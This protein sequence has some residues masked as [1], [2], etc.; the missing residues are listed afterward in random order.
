MLD[1]KLLREQTALVKKNLEKRNDPEKLKMLS[2]FL[3]Y[4]R[5]WRDNLK[6]IEEIR[7]RRNVLTKEM[8]ALNSDRRKAQR[9]SNKKQTGTKIA[10]VKSLRKKA[11]TLEE[12][13]E[14]NRQQALNARMRIPNLLDKSVPVGR[15]DSG[16]VEVRRAGKKPKFGFRPRNH[17]EIAERLGLAD[18]TRA[19]KTAGAG[20]YYLK[21]ELVVLDYA[22]QRFAMDFLTKR[23]FTLIEPP[24]M[25]RRKPY[26][27]VT[28]LSDFELVTYK[29]ESEDAYLIATSEHPMGAMLMDEVLESKHLPIKLCGVS[30]CFRKEIGTHGKYTKGLFRV[31][32]FNKVEQFVF[33][34]PEDSWR[35]HEELQKNSEELYKKLGLHFRVV[36]ICTGDIGTLATKKYDIEVWMADSEFRESGSNSNCTDYQARRLNIRFREKKGAPPAGFVHTLNNTAIATSR[37]MIAILEQYQQKDGSVRIPKAL[38]PYMGGLKAIKPR[39]K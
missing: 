38:Q 12:Q 7:H 11:K 15:D 30:P 14:K 23:G 18:F 31:H 17:V 1:V 6:K 22:L 29:I 9:K 5:K 20:F 21:N 16:N 27:G 35:I 33:C 37:I 24:Y 28:D 26:E 39:K 34:R 36:N 32:Q 19:A 25:I 13:A 8:A 10:E 2:E 3:K 4:D